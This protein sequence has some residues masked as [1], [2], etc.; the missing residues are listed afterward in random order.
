MTRWSLYLSAW[1]IVLSSGMV[2]SVWAKPS[3]RILMDPVVDTIIVGDDFQEILLM[4]RTDR[5]NYQF[6]WTLD[7][8]GSLAGENSAPG[9]IYVP[10]DQMDGDP[11]PV[12]I[13]VSVKDEKDNTAKDQVKIRLL[14]PEK[15][16]LLPE[17]QVFDKD[18]Q[19]IAPKYAVK[20]GETI[21]IEANLSEGVQMEWITARGK[22]EKTEENGVVNYLPPEGRNISK[23]IITLKTRYVP[24]ESETRYSITITI[25]E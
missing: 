2:Q 4:T 18:N 9:L 21:R 11:T 6:E 16:T 7:G 8:P 24:N 3:V 13:S 22:I 14:P 10:P 19:V 5:Q 17:I 1:I 23:D 15:P 25:V 12:I 20:R